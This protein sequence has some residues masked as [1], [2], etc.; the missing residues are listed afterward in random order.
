MMQTFAYFRGAGL[1]H[2]LFSHSSLL[3]GDLCHLF[4]GINVTCIIVF[5]VLDPG[6]I[7]LPHGNQSH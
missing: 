1:R 4:F 5:V 7:R 6:I 3:A 2:A